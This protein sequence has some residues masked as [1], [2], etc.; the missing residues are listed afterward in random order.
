MLA[1]Y[2]KKKKETDLKNSSVQIAMFVKLD[3]LVELVALGQNT[4]GKYCPRKNI[5]RGI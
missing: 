3:R 5:C 2:P 4:T 1:F